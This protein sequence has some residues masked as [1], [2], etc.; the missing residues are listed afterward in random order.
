MEDAAPDTQPQSLPDSKVANDGQKHQQSSDGRS[1][2]KKRCGQ[3]QECRMPDCGTCKFCRDKKKFGGPGKLK[4]SCVKR[5]CTMLDETSL[6]GSAVPTL[7]KMEVLRDLLTSPNYVKL[8]DFPD[9]PIP[10][11]VLELLQSPVQPKKQCDITHLLLQQNR[12][13]QPILGDGNCFF[14]SISFYL[15]NTQKEHLQVRKEI[16]EFI[17]DNTHLF[18]FLVINENENYTLVRHLESVRKP[19]VWASQVEIQAAVDL[20]GVPIYLFT[21]NTSGPG[22]HWQCYSK[23]TFAV[24]ELRHHHIELAHQ[25][26]VHFD[27][28]VDAT[29]MRPCTV[30]PRLSPRICNTVITIQ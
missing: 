30:P 4:K 8:G 18:H 17:S 9:K 15:F 7:S 13:I 23:R 24:P 28:I 11:E 21:P 29:T 22:Y 14:R 2:K 26:S 6:N 3:C 1:N 27:C 19:M 12:K 16:V 10:P 25:S 5:H 20:Y